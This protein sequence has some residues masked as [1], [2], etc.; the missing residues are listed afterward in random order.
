MVCQRRIK[1]ANTGFNS[2]KMDQIM[3]RE[4]LISVV[5]P[6][7]NG[8]KYLREAIESVLN[9]TYGNFEFLII[10]DGSIDQ[11]D[12]IIRSYSD[13]RIVYL[14]NDG[15]RG[16]VYTLNYGISQAKGE[17]IARMDADDISE[18]NRFEKQIEVFKN[19]SEVGLCGTW[20]KIIGSNKIL[21][22]ETDDER[23]KCKLLFKNQFIHSSIMFNR[24]QFLSKSLIYKQE[25]FP[26]EDYALWIESSPKIKMANIPEFLVEYRVHAS[27]ISTES[28]GRQQ[29]KTN[30]LRLK[31]FKLFL[32]HE[33]T[34]EEK[35]NHIQL[36]DS[37]SLIHNSLDLKNMEQWLLKLIDIN[38]KNN[39]Y[40][41]KVFRNSIIEYFEDR[42]IYQNYKN[43]NPLFLFS[44]YKFYIQ[45]CFKFRLSLHFIIIAKCLMFYRYNQH[46]E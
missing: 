20:A 2:S 44:F 33:P 14:Q 4:S 15:N 29:Q 42:F 23:I 3:K 25:N 41:H 9:Q 17:Y 40:D 13:L 18:P 38:N 11:T 24:E 36:I 26:S 32:N 6:V 46:H 27:Q 16:L 22:V 39:F 12:E 43:N 1:P 19:D 28:Y 37:K 10:N 21:K 30:E 31:Q 8:E 5:M 35:R 45:S 7:Y 34:P